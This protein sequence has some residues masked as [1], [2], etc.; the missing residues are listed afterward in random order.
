[1]IKHRQ[2]ILNFLTVIVPVIALIVIPKWTVDDAFISYRYGVNLAQA[3]ELNWN[4]GDPAIEGYT[5]VLLPLLAALFFSIGIN[6][7]TGIKVLG[8]LACLGTAWI[9][10]KSLNELGV[11]PIIQALA[12]LLF[13][14]SPIVYIHAL[15][16]LE[17]IIFTSLIASVLFFQQKLLRSNIST[18]YT[19]I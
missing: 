7:I 8:V 1:M 9:I 6:V 16:G 11:R 14:L 19:F 12:T 5:G 15:S 3:G 4:L 17:T 13:L 10:R 2:R 18:S